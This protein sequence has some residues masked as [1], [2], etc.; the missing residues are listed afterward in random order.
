MSTISKG[1]PSM[2]T[3]RSIGS[4]VVPGSSSTR[5]RCSPASRLSS[6]DL[7]DVGTAHDRQPGVP[8]AGLDAALLGEGVHQGVE[9]VAD[10][11]AVL[12]ADRDRLAEAERPQAVEV[13][14]L[15]LPVHLVGHEQVRHPGAEQQPGDAL[16]VVGHLGGGV[17]QVDDHVG[18][19]RRRL[20]VLPHPGDQRF[21]G[22]ELPTAGIHQEEAAAAPLGLEAA[23]VAGDPGLL[24]DHGETA[25]QD[26]VDQ[27]R[28]ADIGPPDDG[29]H[30]QRGHIADHPAAT[31]L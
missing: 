15:A 28:L 11:A 5:T 31:Q 24:V 13:R 20:R 30:R 29:D 16:V 18:G 27:R 3:T 2:S 9:E 23:G 17:G 7:P 19:S 1:S 8:G 14:L 12:G 6:V 4:R 10:A 22:A 21:V 25:P 26:P